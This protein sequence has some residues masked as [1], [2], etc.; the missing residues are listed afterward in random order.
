MTPPILPTFARL[1]AF[2]VLVPV[3]VGASVLKRLGRKLK[4]IR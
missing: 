2:V 1:L 3:V 4:V